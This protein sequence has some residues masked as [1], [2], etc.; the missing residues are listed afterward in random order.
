[1][2]DK[3]LGMRLPFVYVMLDYLNAAGNLLYNLF[4][5]EFISKMVYRV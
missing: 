2:S 1:M 3:Y 5:H 4:M